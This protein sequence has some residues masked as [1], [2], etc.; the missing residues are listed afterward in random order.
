MG[1]AVWKIRTPSAPRATTSL[2]RAGIVSALQNSGHDLVVA[3]HILDGCEVIELD[4]GTQKLVARY[5]VTQCRVVRSEDQRPALQRFDGVQSAVFSCKEDGTRQR[6]ATTIE[7]LHEWHRSELPVR[8][9]IAHRAQWSELA[10]LSSTDLSRSS[11][12]FPGRS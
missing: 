1:S 5:E 2:C 12:V 4:T 6:L 7:R 11:E 9:E 3:R 10:I 8:L